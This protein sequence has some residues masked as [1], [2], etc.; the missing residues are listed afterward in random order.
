MAG[1]AGALR[2][3]RFTYKNSTREV[4]TAWLYR[5]SICCARG[6]GAGKACIRW[7]AGAAK[8]RPCIDAS[9][10]SVASILLFGVNML[11]RHKH[12][13]VLDNILPLYHGVLR[14]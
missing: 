4:C 9:L 7:L 10:L 12:K 11:W 6:H 2:L 13:G 3:G 5:L 14:L 8:P 1:P